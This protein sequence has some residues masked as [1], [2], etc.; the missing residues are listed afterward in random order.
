MI[1]EINNLLAFNGQEVYY[2]L[3]LDTFVNHVIK[4]E[5]LEILFSHTD[6][7]EDEQEFQQG[8][9]DLNNIPGIDRALTMNLGSFKNLYPF[10]LSLS[11]AK[12]CYPMWKIYGKGDP[13]IM[14]IFNF[15]KLKEVFTHIHPCL[16]TNTENYNKVR[17]FL[18]DSI[19]SNDLGV[20][21]HI[22]HDKILTLFPYLA[23]N[24]AYKY[25]E[26]V[27]IIHEVRD[28]DNTI[29]IQRNNILKQYKKV[30]FPYETLSQIMIGPCREEEF[31]KTAQ[32]ILVLC[33]KHK[34]KHFTNRKIVRSSIPV[35]F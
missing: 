13:G 5:H 16:Y 8:I 33:A 10:Q 11:T 24:N 32:S 26:E 21:N 25:E 9:D 31:A 20:T 12:D 3:S 14:L 7:L 34:F 29:F 23:K 18:Y 19:T 30:I 1:N 15:E 2:Y 4:N 27:R 17:Q 35:R 28:C 6:Y 22:D